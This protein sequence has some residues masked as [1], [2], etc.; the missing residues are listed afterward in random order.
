MQIKTEHGERRSRTWRFQDFFCDH[1]TGKGR[2]SALWSNLGKAAMTFGFV[3]S[4]VHGGSSEWLWLTYGGVV[5]GHEIGSRIMNLKT[6]RELPETV[7]EQ[8][9]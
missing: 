5:C 2:E 1:V 8:R 7:P 3:W 6:A 9:K 4:V